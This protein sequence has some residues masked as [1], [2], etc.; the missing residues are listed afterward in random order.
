MNLE[1]G[2]FSFFLSIFQNLSSRPQVK[3]INIHG[4][5]G[6]F[7]FSSPSR[8]NA[9]HASN[10]QFHVSQKHSTLFLLTILTSYSVWY[11]CVQELHREKKKE[12]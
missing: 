6:G 1:N 8:F 10:M 11:S 3:L 7:H 2:T 9:I 5:F 12:I 4:Y